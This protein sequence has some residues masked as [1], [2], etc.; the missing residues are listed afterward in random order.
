MSA[1]VRSCYLAMSGSVA[2]LAAAVVGWWPGGFRERSEHDLTRES[3]QLIWS[4]AW[5]RAS[6]SRCACASFA[7]FVPSLLL[8]LSLLR[9]GPYLPA[10]GVT[11]AE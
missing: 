9:C 2:R 11:H 3:A 7:A 6:L 4:S 8:S 1:A 5:R 10:I